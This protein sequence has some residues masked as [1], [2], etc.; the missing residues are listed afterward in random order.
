MP[1]VVTWADNER[2]LSAWLGNA[3]QRE[4]MRYIYELEGPVLRSG[5][6]SL[7]SDWRKL[8]TSDHAYYMCTKWFRDGDVHAYFSPYDSPYDAFMHYMNAV[9]DMRWRILEQ[10]KGSI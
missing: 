7:I 5:D 3:M 8:Q 1:Q 2:D 4:A 10:R 9:R 6:E